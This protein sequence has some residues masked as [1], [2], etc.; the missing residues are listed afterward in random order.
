[1]NLSEVAPV[2]ADGFQKLFLGRA[3][4]RRGVREANG[5]DFFGTSDSGEERDR[6]RDQR[7]KP[8]CLG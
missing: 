5:L 2:A 8:S 7:K 3:T 6:R 1:V 4:D